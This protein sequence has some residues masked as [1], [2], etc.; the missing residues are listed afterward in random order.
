MALHN[1]LFLINLNLK[2][3]NA[4]SWDFISDEDWQNVLGNFLFKIADS[5]A[6]ADVSKKADL[7]PSGLSYFSDWAL[8]IIDLVEAEDDVVCRFKLNENCKSRL[9]E[10]EFALHQFEDAKGINYHEFD[11]LSFFSGERLVASYINHEGM[12]DF[13]NLNDD[14]VA[15]SES[16][17]PHIK[18]AFV[19]SSVFTDAFKNR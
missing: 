8:E 16:L 19:D 9:S 7:F 13:L 4:P 18:G 11:Q 12:I 15:I 14:E 3:P 17:E 2:G 5:F 1:K 6:F 10:Y